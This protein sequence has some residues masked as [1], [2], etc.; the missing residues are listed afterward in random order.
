MND[1]AASSADAR[2]AIAERPSAARMPRSVGYI[3]GAEFTERISYYGIQAI[4]VIFMTTGLLARDG[5]P[6]PMPESEAIWPGIYSN[7][8]STQ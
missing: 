4:L 3:I 6:A 2:A 8:A 7:P 1:D 5:T